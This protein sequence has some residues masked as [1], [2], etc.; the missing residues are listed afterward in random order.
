MLFC[1]PYALHTSAL[2]DANPPLLQ[3]LPL[4][5]HYYYTLLVK[6]TVVSLHKQTAPV[7]PLFTPRGHSE[8]IAGAAARPC[9]VAQQQHQHHHANRRQQTL[10]TALLLLL[11]LL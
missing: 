1:C 5:L 7:C 6:H 8:P 2:L 10:R 3:V 9:T 4:L 11:L